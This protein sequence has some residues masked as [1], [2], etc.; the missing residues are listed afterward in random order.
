[1][2]EQMSLNAEGEG[3]QFEDASVDSTEWTEPTVI[4]GPDDLKTPGAEGVTP[5]PEGTKEEGTAEP[6]QS[7]DLSKLETDEKFQELLTRKVQAEVDR[8]EAKRLATAQREGRRASVQAVERANE[9]AL[10]RALTSGDKE[11]AGEIA[12]RIKLE[13]DLRARGANEALLAVEEYLRETPEFVDILG[14]D[15]INKVYKEMQDTNGDL[16]RFIVRLSEERQTVAV[17]K[18]LEEAKGELKEEVEARMEEAGATD[19][20]KQLSE[21]RLN[22]AELGRGAP[23]TKAYGYKQASMD[24]IDGKLSLD[25]FKPIQEAH[26]R[27]LNG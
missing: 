23:G 14:E 21:G 18:A 11:E 4:G 5:P 10:D 9:A 17:K 7:F 2:F 25:K 12:G 6:P 8:R 3:P 1:M 20:S 15:G 16:I 19:R 13:K 22:E 24:Y 26:M 27:D